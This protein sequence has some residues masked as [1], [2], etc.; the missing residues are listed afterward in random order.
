MTTTAGRSII[1]QGARDCPALA[2]CWC[3]ARMLHTTR[4]G[5]RKRLADHEAIAH[6][7]T[8]TARASLAKHRS[9]KR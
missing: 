9:R 5:A 2:I 4:A 7:G 1:D 8:D 6:P 3:G